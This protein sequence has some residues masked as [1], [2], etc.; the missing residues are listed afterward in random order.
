MNK[1]MKQAAGRLGTVIFTV[2][3]LT[4]PVM[5]GGLT[6]VGYST[7][8]RAMA[9]A[10]VAYG[11]D[12]MSAVVNPANAASVGH[13]F[14][15]GVNLSR[16][17]QGYVAGGPALFVWPG[18]FQNDGKLFVL[19]NLSYNRPLDN[20]AVI[21]LSVYNS[22]RVKTDYVNVGPGVYNGGDAGL[23]L[24]QTSI[25]LT[26][27]RKTGN[28]SWGISP[29]IV[30]QRLS[31]TG[32]SAFAMAGLS[33]DPAALTNNGNDWSY[34]IGLK[35]GIVWDASPVLSLGLSGQTRTKMSALDK[36][37][38]FLVDGGRLDIPASVT[39]GAAW[40]VKP[41]VKVMLDYQRIFYSGVPALSNTAS[42]APG[43][44]GTANGTGFGWDDVDV[45]K[46]GVE[47]K[48]NDRMTWRAGYAHSQ[49]PLRNS[50]IDNA[51]GILMP[52]VSEHH[53]T[54][55]GS[56][57]YNDKSAFDFAIGYSPK[58]TYSATGPLGF[59]PIELNTRQLNVSLGWTHKF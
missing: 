3:T 54:L 34:G 8:Q 29:T 31:V 33:S 55:G 27:A 21:N 19:P 26:Y 45:V 48:A 4:T 9:G 47:W 24:S 11:Y 25:S 10:G 7:N 38:G 51:L 44:M 16:P 22:G 2:A 37:A 13:Q 39:I 6:P 46:L 30:A 53:I 28:L 40:D 56:Y 42:V 5:A 49:N 58:A 14:Q 59:Q 15:L 20:G 36:Y 12:A 18:S 32:L 50:T 1:N 17:D 57:A 23:D 52:A 43:N 35:A 41:N